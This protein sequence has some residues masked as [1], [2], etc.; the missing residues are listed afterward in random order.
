VDTKS[1]RERIEGVGLSAV[2]PESRTPEFLAKFLPAEIEK[3]A[4]A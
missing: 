3:W 4:A 2:P 1:A